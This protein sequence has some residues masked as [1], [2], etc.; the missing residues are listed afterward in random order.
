[1]SDKPIPESYWVVPGKFLA[2][3]Y[4]IASADEMVARQCLS[5]FIDAGINSFFDLTRPGELPAYLPILQEEAVQHG[6]PID[7]QRMTIQDKGLPS[8]EKMAVL[9]DALD[10]ALA[11]RPQG[12]PALL[13]RHRAHR[14]DRRLLAGATWLDRATGADPL[15]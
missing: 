10:A 4:P 7:Y 9:L 14:Y 1:M 3:G 11:F 15:E 8:H 6:I 2:G 12:L 5:A 13:G